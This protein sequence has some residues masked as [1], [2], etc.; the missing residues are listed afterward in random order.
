MLMGITAKSLDGKDDRGVAVP[1]R[2][3]QQPREHPVPWLFG[4]M[5]ADVD[6]VKIMSAPADSDMKNNSSAD[7]DVIPSDLTGAHKEGYLWQSQN[8]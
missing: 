7:A 4:D 5:S 1:R 8:S 2:I 6:A 3:G